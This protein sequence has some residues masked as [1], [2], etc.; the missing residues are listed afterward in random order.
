[1]GILTRI[2]GEYNQIRPHPRAKGQRKDV[3]WRKG[4]EYWVWVPVRVGADIPPKWKKFYRI[5]FLSLLS[6]ALR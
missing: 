3:R 2:T 5:K 6:C 1:M 4:H